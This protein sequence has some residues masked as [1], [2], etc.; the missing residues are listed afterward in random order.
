MT[1]GAALFLFLLPLAALPVVFHLL[2]RRRR[3][4]LVFSTL[5]FFHRVDPRLSSRRRLREILLLACRVLLIAL[6]LVALSRLTLHAS[7]GLLGLHGT[8]AA[9]IVL[10]N[11]ASMGA[12]APGAAGKTKL[13]VAVEGARALLAH[14]DEGAEA[15]VVLLVPDPAAGLDAAGMTADA[16]GLARSLDRVAPTEGTG[17]VARALGR[18]G[19]LLRSTSPGGAGAVHVF[20]DLQEAEWA[21]QKVDERGLSE[22]VQV[23][24]HRVPTAPAEGPNVAVVQA[25][26]IGRRILPRQPYTVQVV[27]RND[28]PGPAKVRLNSEDDQRKTTTE[29]VALAAGKEKTVTLVVQPESPGYHWVRVW[30]EGDRF[31]GDNR[32]AVGYLC[33][34]KALVL[35]AGEAAAYG[36]L[37]AALSPFGDGRFTSLVLGYASAADLRGRVERDRPALVVLTWDDWAAQGQAA[38]LK[39]YVSRGGN[40]AVLPAAGGPGS[41]ANAPAWLGARAGA[42]QSLAEEAPAKVID[43]TAPFWAGLRDAEGRLRLGPVRARQFCPLTLARD[44][45]YASLLGLGPEKVLLAAGRLGKGQVVLSG[46]AFDPSWT[47]LPRLK[48]VVVVAQTMALGGRA[49]EASGLSLVAGAAPDAL[50]GKGDQIHIVSLVGD[51]LDWSGPRGQ[52]PAFPRSGAY[53]VRVGEESF[54]LSV[55]G[56][57][58]EG[59]TRCIETGLVPALG[60]VPHTVRPLTEGDLEAA[61]AAS[62]TGLPLYLPLLALAVLGLVAESLLGAPPRRRGASQGREVTA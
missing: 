34:G 29:A 41:A 49:P 26:L 39:E 10:D 44:K 53:S 18:S 24:F 20:T 37:P 43:R 21:Q 12:A 40:L 17:N 27:L 7:G 23:V 31:A 55:R 6:V 5:M 50:P 45:G 42:R 51:P 57:D 36:V 38:W 35:L 22:D 60:R 30:V 54:C 14:L 28:G 13:Q 3:K 11:S 16:D 48:S 8:Q 56:S 15:A 4:K 33:E 2:M 1:A 9:V 62:R 61:L 32:A 19:A 59:G 25:E 47:T 58:R 46:L 52:V